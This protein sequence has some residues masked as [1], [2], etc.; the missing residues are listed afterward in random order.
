MSQKQIWKEYQFLGGLLFL[1]LYWYFGYDGIAFSDDVTYL[2]FGQS[3]WTGEAFPDDSHFGHRWGAFLFSGLF[4]F[5]FGF[6]DWIGSLASLIFVLGTYSLLYAQFKEKKQRFWFILFF[7]TQVYFLHF[8][9]KVFPD[10]LLAFWICL[11]PVTATYR[12]K[13]PMTMS[14]VMALAF[15]IGFSTKEMMVFL[16]PF[17]LILFYLDWKNGQNLQ[18]YAYFFVSSAFILGAYFTAY[19]LITGDILSRFASVNE[20]HYIS[21]FTYADKGL[22]AVLKRLTYLPFLI[23]VE[24]SYWIWLVLGLPGIVKAF[25]TKQPF[26]FEMALASICLMFGFWFMSSTLEFYNPI[27]L[28]PRHLIILVPVLAVLIA[29]GFSE[30]QG[31]KN[32]IFGFILF[33]ALISIFIGDYKMTAYLLVFA[34]AFFFFL[35]KPLLQII[36]PLLLIAPVILSVVYQHQNKNFTYFK[37][38]LNNHV[39]NLKNE[40][41][42][43]LN[44]FVFFGKEVIISP[45]NFTDSSLKNIQSDAAVIIDSG[46][47]F[48]LFVYKYYKHAYPNEKQYLE[49]LSNKAKSNGYVENVLS[50]D[51]W[52]VIS[53]FIKVD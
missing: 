1:S 50:E 3:L 38:T 42:I 25:K 28:N 4:T 6:S 24:R 14:L 2:K 33:G 26:F 11:V 15:I 48:K 16:L 49:E 30:W 22:G 9:N 29:Y 35:Q 43:I 10:P 21:E 53:E 18:F 20:G 7:C 47:S 5:L 40:D 51:K 52:I 8:N 41:V 19:H 39:K 37:Y 46:Q 12:K 45:Q 23:F 34:F 36:L 32:W 13:Y 44:N 17:P 27:Y 31:L